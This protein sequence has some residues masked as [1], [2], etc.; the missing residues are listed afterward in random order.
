VRIDEE[1]EDPTIPLPTLSLDT[2]ESL[3]DA[4]VTIARREPRLEPERPVSPRSDAA[5]F[6]RP[7]S[8]AAPTPP[9]KVEPEVDARAAAQTDTRDTSPEPPQKIVTLRIAA[10]PAT[11]FDG[12]RLREAIATLGL[13]FGRYRIFHRL[14]A[15]GRSVFSLASLQEPGTFDPEAMEGAT[16]RGLAMFAVLPGPWPAARTLDDVLAT[17]RALATRLGGQ[18][19]DERGSPLTVQRVGDLRRDAAEFERSRLQAAAR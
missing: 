7:S 16:F 17:A 1:I 10:M 8:V 3:E 12:A 5:R 19:Q 13:V 9:P 14:D 15:S 4:E 18:L 6:D 11:P 2:A